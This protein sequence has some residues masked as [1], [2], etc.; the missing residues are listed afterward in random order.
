MKQITKDWALKHRYALVSGGSA[1]LL[2]AVA[3][4]FSR[5]P[6]TQDGVVDG[7]IVCGKDQ[8]DLI[9][10]F[11][12]RN[13]EEYQIELKKLDEWMSL[14]VTPAS[15]SSEGYIIRTPK[16]Q[17]TVRVGDSSYDMNGNTIKEDDTYLAPIRKGDGVYADANKLFGA[18]GYQPEYETNKDDDVVTMTLVK[19]AQ[20]QYGDLYISHEEIAEEETREQIEES[21]VHNEPEFGRP[22][23]NELPTVPVPT[24]TT[25]FS[26]EE[27]LANGGTYP[28]E[29]QEIIDKNPDPEE[30]TQA[31]PELPSIVHKPEENPNKKTDKEFQEQWNDT[32]GELESIYS[33][34][35]SP[36]GSAPYEKRGDNGIAYIPMEGA[37]YYDTISVN[38][39]PEGNTYVEATFANE[40]SDMAGNTDN[41]QVQ[42]FYNSIPGVVE[43]TLKSILGETAGGELFAFIKEHADRTQ[44]GGYISRINEENR[45]ETV[46]TDG[47]VG[48]GIQANDIDFEAWEEKFT[49]D[50]LRFYAARSGDGFAVKVFK[51]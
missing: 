13:G 37:L 42:A 12:Y 6:Q 25:P 39:Y 41:P 51:N 20:D 32:I 17:I 43:S 50:G 5:Q 16:Q 11:L 44:T 29:V 48:D 38:Y 45:L 7:Y 22:G 36:S 14:D 1:L 4:G 24:E 18:F 2:A 3:F 40:W 46:W 33:G 19:T 27:F 26:E 31:E 30:T 49:D 34:G 23:E 9:E 10:D 15:G 35:S 8:T 47:P 21:A 28:D